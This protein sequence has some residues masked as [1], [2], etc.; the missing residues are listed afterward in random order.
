MLLLLPS[1]FGCLD[2]FAIIEE[3]HAAFVAGDEGRVVKTA[4]NACNLPSTWDE[5]LTSTL[6]LIN[7]VCV[8]VCRMRARQVSW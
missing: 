7:D 8:Q 3:V 2:D 5:R 6:F 4:S 1:Q